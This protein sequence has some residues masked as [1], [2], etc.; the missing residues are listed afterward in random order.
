M[1]HVTSTGDT[2]VCQ[3][4]G[5]LPDSARPETPTH[6]ACHPHRTAHRTGRPGA[7]HPEGKAASGIAYATS[8]YALGVAISGS[9]AYVAYGTA[10]LQVID[11]SNPAN[12]R[13][14]PPPSSAVFHSIFAAC[15]QGDLVPRGWCAPAR[16]HDESFAA[17]AI[18]RSA[19]LVEPVPGN[20][21]GLSLPPTWSGEPVVRRAIEVARAGLVVAGESRDNL[22]GDGHQTAPAEKT[23]TQHRGC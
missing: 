2:H 12:P 22:A 14:H 16:F 10:G 6:G 17:W 11:V 13:R 20:C 21:F 15:T 7:A 1:P 18:C 23:S 19:V 8:G 4:N 5:Q 9:H 3:I